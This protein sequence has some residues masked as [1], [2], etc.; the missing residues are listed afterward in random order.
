MDMI[1]KMLK[2][3][4][5]TYMFYASDHTR[6]AVTPDGECE[7]NDGAGK[8]CAVGRYMVDP[9]PSDD[10]RV[11]D[12]FF[13]GGRQV[14]KSEV[15]DLPIRFWSAVQVWHDSQDVWFGKAFRL[16][17]PEAKIP[18]DAAPKMGAVYKRYLEIRER[19]IKGEFVAGY[20]E[21]FLN[22]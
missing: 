9:K 1:N 19:V 18:V 22:C 16:L 10:G 5:E 20:D 7:Y 3:L 15:R 14:M 11:H 6:R 8:Y 17:G 4:D 12:L 13:K 21:D 2:V